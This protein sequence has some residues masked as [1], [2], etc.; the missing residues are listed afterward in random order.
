MKIWQSLAAMV[1][2]K[3]GETKKPKSESFLFPSHTELWSSHEPRFP[4]RRS[5]VRSI[6]LHLC[7][8]SYKPSGPSSQGSNQPG[9]LLS[10]Q[11]RKPMESTSEMDL[12]WSPPQ[13]W[14]LCLPPLHCTAS[15]LVQASGLHL[16]QQPEGTATASLLA[17]VQSILITAATVTFLKCRYDHV[18]L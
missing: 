1:K 15:A 3:R 11:G 10:P 4:F 2:A 12:L 9:V 7:T 18:S 5:G 13:K 6:F 8:F 17:A 16:H 14:R